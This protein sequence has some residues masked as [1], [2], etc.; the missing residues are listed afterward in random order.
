M[1]LRPVTAAAGGA[2]L[3]ALLA[4]CSSS[5]APTPSSTEET[6]TLTAGE[7][8]AAV[9]RCIEDRGWS[10]ALTPDNGLTFSDVPPEQESELTTAINECQ[11]E[12][13][14]SPPTPEN[15]NIL[16]KAEVEQRLCLIGLGYELPEPPTLATYIDTYTTDP[17]FAI[18]DAS[19]ETMSPAKYAEVLGKCPSP[20]L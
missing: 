13:P 16:Y 15:L 5:P 7:R 6:A 20:T 17:W 2:M 12:Y 3:I 1:S 8:I 18:A 11:A 9:K 4:A 10:V 19:P 14:V